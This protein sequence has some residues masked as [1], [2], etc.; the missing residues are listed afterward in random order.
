MSPLR[1]R[2][3]GALRLQPMTVVQLSICLTMGS[4]TVRVALDDLSSRCRVSRY[5]THAC[6]RRVGK[7]PYV[8][9]L[10]A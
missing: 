10:R 4:N 7:P 2:I 3:L 6:S 5:R 1:D 9:E 8:Y